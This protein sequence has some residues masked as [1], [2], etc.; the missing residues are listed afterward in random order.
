M[1]QR[2]KVLVLGTSLFG[3]VGSYPKAATDVCFF[4]KV[5]FIII[6]Q[7]N[8]IIPYD[9]FIVFPIADKQIIY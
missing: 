2:S 7:M 8:D 1:A 4:L 9:T 3:G 5:D 6:L